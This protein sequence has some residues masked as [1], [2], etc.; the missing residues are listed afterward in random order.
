MQE[1][2]TISALARR[3]GVSSKT[4][5]YWERRGLLPRAARSHTGYRLFDS[6]S[7][8]YVT[9]IQ[10]SKGI[11]LTLAEMQEILRLARSGHCPCP[12]VIDWTNRKIGSLEEQ[13]HSL[14]ALLHRLKR[15]RRQWSQSSCP[16]GECG[17]VCRL[18]AELPEAK[19]VKGGKTHAK[20]VAGFV[21]GP[22]D[23]C[24]DRV[25]GSGNC[26]G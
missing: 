24:C 13:I 18:I 15:I 14:S 23:A 3:A 11:G 4:L 8:Q 12:E 26:G 2:L 16:P 5:R 1:T 7:L 9:F 17:D 21:R 25:T 19:S 6:G 22:G 10:K 20:I